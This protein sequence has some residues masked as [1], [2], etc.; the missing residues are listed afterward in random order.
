MLFLALLGAC[1]WWE[2]YQAC[3]AARE[4]EA[5]EWAALTEQLGPAAALARR[6]AEAAAAG[7]AA[8][9]RVVVTPAATPVE[10]PAV[11]RGE[12]AQDAF[13]RASRVGGTQSGATQA[14][15]VDWTARAQEQA[16]EAERRT[17]LTARAEERLALRGRAAKA[18]RVALA[19]AYARHEA[20]MRTGTGRAMLALDPSQPVTAAPADK[21]DA[22]LNERSAL[23]EARSG[24]AK[25]AAAFEEALKEAGAAA[26]EADR[27]GQTAQTTGAGF[28]FMEFPADAQPAEAASLAALSAATRASAAAAHL[29]EAAARW[30]LEN[31]PAEPANPALQATLQRAVEAV[32]AAQLACE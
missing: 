20:V 6:E 24:H 23:A 1:G 18:S 8:H 14:R 9:V 31:G 17:E 12:A 32:R 19:L 3:E 2:K 28:R 11:S 13:T 26:Y 4:L 29:R 21:P 15:W 25:Q 22:G 7:A 30:K 5:T 10:A 27:A 16:A